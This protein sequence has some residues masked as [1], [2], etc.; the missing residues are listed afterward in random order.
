MINPENCRLSAY[1]ADG[2]GYPICKRERRRK[3]ISYRP[4]F[5]ER[6]RERLETMYGEHKRLLISERA[7]QRNGR[8][9][10][11]YTGPLP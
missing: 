11:V 7:R 3:H 2:T 6:T 1:T 5:G 9:F 8:L 10:D 4:R